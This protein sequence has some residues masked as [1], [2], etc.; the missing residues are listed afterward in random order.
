MAYLACAYGTYIAGYVVLFVLS[1]T[2]S[3]MAESWVAVHTVHLV[4]RHT[5]A[6]I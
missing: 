5:H 2:W 6:R 4:V 3:E 1:T